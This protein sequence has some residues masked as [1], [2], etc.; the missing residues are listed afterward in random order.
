MNKVKICLVV[1]ILVVGLVPVNAQAATARA[2]PVSQGGP[3]QEFVVV[4][5]EGVSLDAAHAA[6]AAAGGRVVKENDRVGVATVRTSRSDFVAA[7]RQQKA[8][9][10]AVRNV[11]IGQVPRDQRPNRNDVERLEQ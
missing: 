9:L 1:L 8:L 7:A 11:S 4:Y 10:G 3:E 6:I 5:T 2:G